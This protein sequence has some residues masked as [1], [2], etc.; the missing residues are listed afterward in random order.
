MKGKTL[1]SC[2]LAAAVAGL[3]LA[4]PFM[5]SSPAAAARYT[6]QIRVASSTS[7]AV[8]VYYDIGHGF[9]ESDS[10]I[11]NVKGG[12]PAAVLNFSLPDG[13]YRGLRFDPLNAAGTV[14]FSGARILTA[15]GA[16]VTTFAPRDFQPAKQ[17]AS[18]S[19]EGD[20]MTIVTTPGADDPILRLPLAHRLDLE[21]PLSAEL[22]PA[23]WI[24]LW[25][26]G[27]IAVLT[28]ALLLVPARRRALWGEAIVRAWRRLAARPR[29]LLALVAA[30]AVI[31]SCYPVVFLG[32][33]FV[34]PNYGTPLLYDHYP[35]LPGYH[36]TKIAN[37]EGADV[38]AIIWQQVP[39]SMMQHRAL[40]RN[41]ELPLWNRYNSAGV[42]L[43]GQ[44]QSMFGDPLHFLVIIA[45]G[46]AWAWDLKYLIAKW[47]FAFGLGLIVWQLTRHPPSAALTTVTS[48]FIGFFVFRVNHP[49][50]FSVC[51][52]PWIL[53]CWVRIVEDGALR[54]RLGW[55]GWLLLANWTEMNSGTVKEAYML[56][57]GLNL[58]GAIL[59]A[60]AAQ[61]WRR[62][63]R[64]YG[65]LAAGGA[66]FAL[67]S[68]PIWLTFLESL[69]QSYTSYDQ[70]WVF[71]IQPGMLLGL[72]DGIFYRPLQA[73][74][75]VFCPSVNFVLML[76]ALYFVATL[77]RARHERV[78][79]GLATAAL[80]PLAFAF[81]LVP[82][83]WIQAVP[84][85]ANVSHVDNTFSCVLII[86][87][88]P[89]AGVGF[90]TAWRRLA[91]PEGRGD[92]AVTLGLLGVIV[93][94]YL[95]FGQ[96]VHRQ[97]YG[98]GQTFTVWHWGQRMPIDGFVWGTLWA[99]LAASA[100]LLVLARHMRRRREVTVVT[101]LLAAAC[102]MAMCWRQ[103]MQVD[104]SGNPYVLHTGV[105]VDL[106]A[107]SRAVETVLAD[108]SAPFRVA[109]FGDTLMPGWTG[110]YGLE[111]IA[112]PD[113]L[114]NRHYRE[115]LDA[116]RFAREWDWRR[117]VRAGTL[118]ALK[119]VY[120]FLNIKYYF[121][122]PD[123]HVRPGS[124]L[125]PV[126]RADLD[127]FRSPTVWPRAFFTDEILSYEVPLQMA[128]LIQSHPDEPF[129]AVQAGERGA[130]APVWRA[131]ADRHVVPAQDYHLTADST[132]FEV[133]APDAGV[134][135]LQ[136]AWLPD[137]FRVTV[138]GHRAHYFRVNHAFKGVS[139]PGPGT[140]RVT[141]TYWPVHFTLALALCGVGAL[142]LVGGCLMIRRLPS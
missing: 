9:I 54:R 74:E 113:A 127:V 82:V 43:L 95:S 132:S 104:F 97:L 48:A 12:A 55:I 71:Q 70:A 135:V 89:L 52:A 23:L 65:A 60:F 85:L 90:W 27:V 28:V 11:I 123:E 18:Q 106:H 131:P 14:T 24:Y 3:I 100:L 56:L 29:T 75:R 91:T 50:F 33:S 136:E 73:L 133:T 69:K 68:A 117:V 45:N 67:L 98:P 37:P 118:A 81:G 44:G 5:G 20:R 2:L 122:D 129:A 61:P 59:L 30:V 10:T 78:V 58:T 25:T 77:R 8:Q 124:L 101:G 93:F 38:G 126:V 142:L 4:L 19:V 35:T 115:L 16:V 46:A 17:I 39:F 107:Q 116:C 112:G 114:M 108:K 139:V 109:G 102:V 134:I 34:T 31:T 79:L 96:T 62:K 128:A 7:G 15:S 86:H 13:S 110:V 94:S 84:F 83:T 138:N 36:S 53:Y 119:P 40:F 111:G 103:S 66:I 47:L 57:V 6:F 140:Y 63:L 21:P 32:R 41:A 26:F 130:P 121:A 64:L 88:I 22:L 72:F 42:A 87:L 120:D 80:V 1:L 51:Y 76:G 49:A 105:R 141:F 125:K 99:L 137:S 92:I